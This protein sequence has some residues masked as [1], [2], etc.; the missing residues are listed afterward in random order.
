[1]F[2]T[3]NS[4]DPKSLDARGGGKN[5][6]FRASSKHSCGKDGERERERERR[7]ILKSNYKVTM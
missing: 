1:M 5:G 3:G 4:T 7:D 2:L 6:D